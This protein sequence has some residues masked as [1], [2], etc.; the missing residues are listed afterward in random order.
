VKPSDATT[1]NAQVY[2]DNDANLLILDGTGGLIVDG[3]SGTLKRPANL[4]V[5]TVTGST[6]EYGQSFT[7]PPVPNPTPFTP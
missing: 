5:T 1:T 3:L 4:N 7:I 2:S 6:L